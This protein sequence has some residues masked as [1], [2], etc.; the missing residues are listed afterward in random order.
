MRPRF[1]RT[2]KQDRG[3]VRG[4]RG[5]GL[6][7]RTLGSS[8]NRR[9]AAARDEVDL[10][11][12][13]GLWG[14]LEGDVGAIGGPLRVDGPHGWK[15]HLPALAAVQAAAYENAGGELN[16]GHPPAVV[17]KGDVVG[18]DASNVRNKLTRG[19]VIADQLAAQLFAH[20]EN[21]LAVF[22]RGGQV[23]G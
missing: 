5:I 18:G 15:R 3:S 8:Q 21:T 10:L 12:C 13:A 2:G 4:P 11:V 7:L 16:V 1:I 14:G 17:G 22:T 9:A 23:E 20:G 19:L 6:P